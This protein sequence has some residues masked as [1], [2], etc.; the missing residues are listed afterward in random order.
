MKFIFPIVFLVLNS[1]DLALAQQQTAATQPG[2]PT[3]DRTKS[4][5]GPAAISDEDVRKKW[6][7][8]WDATIE[9]MGRDGKPVTNP[10]KAT[11]KLAYGGKWLVTEFEGTFM[12]AAFSGQ[13]LLGYDSA[14]KKYPL[15]WID[16]AATSFSTGEGTFDPKTNTMTF[17]VNGRDDST[18][19]MAT[20]RQVDVWKDADHHEWSI[21]T[22]SKDGNEYIQMTI[23][24]RRKS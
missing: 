22:I 15:N 11:V 2:T 14:T 1:L 12:G 8:N 13:E 20:W 3:Q 24:Y 19:E 5:T 7:G 23:R 10:A 6:V 16:S 18:G 21:R 9:S 17:T 4:E